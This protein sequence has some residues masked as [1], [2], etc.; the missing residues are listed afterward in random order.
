MAGKVP[1]LNV[2]CPSEMLELLMDDFKYFEINFFQAQDIRK[3]RKYMLNMKYLAY[4]LLQRRGIEITFPL[5]RT[6]RRIKELDDIFDQV[7]KR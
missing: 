5:L 6:K 1:L 2:E 7:I 4:K 3:E